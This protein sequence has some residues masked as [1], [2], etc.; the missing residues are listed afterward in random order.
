MN[1]FFAMGGYAAFVWP[2]YIVAFVLLIAHVVLPARRRRRLLN[3]IQ[4]HQR[5]E[6]RAAAKAT[7]GSEA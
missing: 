4:R 5:R 1:E 3:E 6:Q 2:S 7:A